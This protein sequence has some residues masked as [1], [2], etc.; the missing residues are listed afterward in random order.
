MTF[1]VPIVGRIREI[2]AELGVGVIEA[3]KRAIREAAFAAI[4]EAK[5]VD[6]LKPILRTLLD[7]AP[8]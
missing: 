7:K 8:L 2:A 1:I 5:T 6:D 3:K 4:T